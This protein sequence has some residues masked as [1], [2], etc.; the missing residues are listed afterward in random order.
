MGDLRLLEIPHPLAGVG[1]DVLAGY[2]ATALDQLR[3]MLETP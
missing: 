2:A 3:R 1:A